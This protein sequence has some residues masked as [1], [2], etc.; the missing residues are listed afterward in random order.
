MTRLRKVALI[1][2]LLLSVISSGCIGGGYTLQ[3]ETLKTTT[4]TPTPIKQQTETPPITSTSATSSK[5]EKC[6]SAVEKAMEEDEET[7]SVTVTN[8]TIIEIR[9][10]S[11]YDELIK[12][13]EP[14]PFMKAFLKSRYR[15]INE[16]IV[17]VAVVRWERTDEG[18]AGQRVFKYYVYTIECE[19]L[20][21]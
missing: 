11:N 2:L 19:K 17:K 4:N 12:F 20:D 10:V 13:I 14:F 8:P 9:K 16:P 7:F 15:N 21:L 5:T 1:G 18:N 3:K 6:R